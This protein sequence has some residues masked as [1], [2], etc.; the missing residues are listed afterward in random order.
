MRILNLNSPGVKANGK[1]YFRIEKDALD[2]GRAPLSHAICPAHTSE[3]KCG[4]IR[5]LRL[6]VVSVLFGEQF[7]CM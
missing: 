7:K 2:Q 4:F 5:R 3:L 1:S 6:L